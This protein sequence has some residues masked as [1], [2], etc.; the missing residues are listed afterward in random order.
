MSFLM[1]GYKPAEDASEA[2]KGKKIFLKEGESKQIHFL[3]DE[4]VGVYE[5][6]FYK[7]KKTFTCLEGS[8][9]A[10][11][12]C[13]GGNN[14]KY[15]GYFPVIDSATNKVCML[16]RGV[17]DVGALKL[18]NESVKKNLFNGKEGSGLKSCAFMM[19]RSGEG[20]NT[21]YNFM[22]LVGVITTPE[23][24][25]R[26]D[27]INFELKLAPKKRS[28]I[29]GILSGIGSSSNSEDDPVTSFG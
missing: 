29:L 22:P 23:M 3:D 24:L 21:V 18:L 6:N 4:P 10:C 19:T 17:K 7:E 11:P 27:E 25:A 16:G 2:M 5:H 28:E 20:V 26:K 1:K 9:E 13:E 15:T 8:G 14:K 12:M